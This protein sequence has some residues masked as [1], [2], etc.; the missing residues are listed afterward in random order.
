MSDN[1]LLAVNLVSYF[2]MIIAI[3]DLVGFSLSMA[4]HPQAG[5]HFRNAAKLL[6]L[7]DMCFILHPLLISCMRL[8]LLANAIKQL[9]VYLYH[10][11][12]QLFQLVHFLYLLL[13]GLLEVIS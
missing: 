7:T 3:A 10:L 12:S 5:A 2:T 13:D 8:G 9:L 11:A 4:S 6:H 1:S